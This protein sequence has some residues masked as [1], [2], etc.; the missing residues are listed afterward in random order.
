MTTIWWISTE[1]MYTLTLQND[2]MPT[3]ST[4]ATKHIKWVRKLQ[5]HTH[6]DKEHWQCTKAH[7]DMVML[8]FEWLCL[9][10]CTVMKMGCT[11]F[12]W[13][14]LP[15]LCFWRKH[16]VF[17]VEKEKASSRHRNKSECMIT[18]IY[19]DDGR[20]CLCHE[21]VFRTCTKAKHKTK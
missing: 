9:L 8:I 18:H 21:T 11:K 14:Q 19:W 3:W 17:Y 12:E 7:G 1:I 13:V 4:D 6:C 5:H 10:W 16:F 20:A 2:S 15:K